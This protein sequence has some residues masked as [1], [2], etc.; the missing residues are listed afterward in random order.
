[1]LGQG[2]LLL[3]GDRGEVGA[4]EGRVQGCQHLALAHRHAGLD[5]QFADDAPLQGLDHDGR[6]VGDQAAA[7]G[8]HD[9][10]FEHRGNQNQDEEQ[11][12]DEIMG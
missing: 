12:N 4:G 6:G 3:G 7:A 8:E 9:I 2:G 1:M 11:Q 5:L 10:G